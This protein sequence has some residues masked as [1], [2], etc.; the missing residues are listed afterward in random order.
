M[1]DPFV[2]GI[3]GGTGAG[4]TTLARHVAERLDAPVTRVA[5]DDY[6]EPR[7][8]LSPAERRELNY[9]H[10]A[11]FDWTLLVDHL[12]ALRAG[13]AVAMPEYDFAA[14]DR[15]GT[16]RVTAGAVVLVEGILALH[17]PRVRDRLDLCVYV[18][19][20]ADVRVLRRV[21]RDV[22]ERD[23]DLEGVVEQYLATVKPMHERHVAPTKTHADVVVPEGANERAVRLL[24]DRLRAALA[25]D[26]GPRDAPPIE[27][28]EPDPVVTH[29]GHAAPSSAGTA[30]GAPD[31]NG[32]GGTKTDE[33]DDTDAGRQ[34]SR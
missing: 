4:K 18:Q 19:T 23:R 30:D 13:E 9:D 27:F 16:R 22:V 28:D 6:Y 1:T 17:D 14:D 7:P 5:L 12:D 3:A 21:R 24:A 31:T 25:G 29:S 32:D 11:A 2:V 15:V 26:D 34:P 8:D 33:G 20:D 10:P